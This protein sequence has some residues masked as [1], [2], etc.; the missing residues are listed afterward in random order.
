VIE[1]VLELRVNPGYFQ[2][3]RHK[4]QQIAAKAWTTTR[5]ADDEEPT[6]RLRRG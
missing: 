6:A 1:E 3:L 2:Y 4:L 5:G